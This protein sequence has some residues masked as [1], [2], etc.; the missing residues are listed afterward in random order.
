MISILQME[1]CMSVA[2]PQKALGNI[3][4]HSMVSQCSFSWIVVLM[5]LFSARDYLPKM[6]L[7]L[8]L[9]GTDPMPILDVLQ[10]TMIYILC[11]RG[12]AARR[13]ILGLGKSGFIR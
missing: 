11:P 6:R 3:W 2:E 10:L 5:P 9:M 13:K 7:I 12:R 8:N 1:I 4:H